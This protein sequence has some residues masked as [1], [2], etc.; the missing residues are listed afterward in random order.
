VRYRGPAA[1]ALLQ[2]P[3]D[4]FTAVFH[5]PSGITHLLAEPAPQILAALGGGEMDLDALLAALA[6]EHELVGA[7]REAL[8]ERLGELTAAGLVEAR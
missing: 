4:L 5:R 2:A 7:T 8:V 3:L 6:V 1:D